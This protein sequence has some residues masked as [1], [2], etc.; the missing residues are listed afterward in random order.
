MAQFWI[1]IV[2]LS[3]SI[4][5]TPLLRPRL[6]LLVELEWFGGWRRAGRGE[7]GAGGGRLFFPTE[8]R[9]MCVHLKKSWLR[10][11]SS[12]PDFPGPLVAELM[13]FHCTIYNIIHYAVYTK[14][15]IPLS[16]GDRPIPILKFLLGFEA[17]RGMKKR[18]L[19]SRFSYE[20]F[21][22]FFFLFSFP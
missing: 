15:I 8:F 9:K 21:S 19:T 22:H 2:H 14:T 10:P 13:R 1:K 3:F 4:A 17:V 12:R 16:V 6:W 5:T 7:G 20:N 18:E 11:C